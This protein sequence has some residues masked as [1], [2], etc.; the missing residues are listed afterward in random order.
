MSQKDNRVRLMRVNHTTNDGR[1]IIEPRIPFGVPLK[2]R[3]VG[4]KFHDHL[5]DVGAVEHI[6]RPDRD[7]W[8]IGRLAFNPGID[9]DPTGMIASIGM[10]GAKV[11]DCNGLIGPSILFGGHLRYT[12]L[13]PADE[14]CWDDMVIE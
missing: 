4:E 11:I 9:V 12:L 1:L 13:A 6:E 2:M 3:R 7:D 8:V 10:H 14:A 5:V